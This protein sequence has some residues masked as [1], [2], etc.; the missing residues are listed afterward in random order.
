MA[1]DL[2]SS[3]LRSSGDTVDFTGFIFGNVDEKGNLEGDC[4]LNKVLSGR[5]LASS[6][7]G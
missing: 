4:V 1:A 5:R 2:S 6:G 3:P 7:N